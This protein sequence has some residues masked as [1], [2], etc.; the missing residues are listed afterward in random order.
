MKGFFGSK[1]DRRGEQIERHTRPSTTL[2]GTLR[3]IPIIR[4]KKRELK[5]IKKKVGRR[6]EGRLGTGKEEMEEK[7]SAGSRVDREGEWLQKK[8]NANKEWT[9]P[10]P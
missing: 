10:N 5:Q 8:R 2:K 9:H 3:N 4:G 6:V 1:Q 7:S